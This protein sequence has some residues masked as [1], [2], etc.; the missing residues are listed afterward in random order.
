M[1]F[2]DHCT[3]PFW[4]NIGVDAVTQVEYMTRAVTEV[5]QCVANRLSNDRFVSVQNARV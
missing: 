5:S 3:E 2:I 4:F 1:H